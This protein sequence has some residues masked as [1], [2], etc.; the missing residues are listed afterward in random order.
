M[1]KS[2]SRRAGGHVVVEHAV[3]EEVDVPE[4]RARVLLEEVVL[5]PEVLPA[6]RTRVP[7]CRARASACSRDTL[8]HE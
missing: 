8:S 7:R 4:A 1:H 6:R 2:A 3:P 5:V